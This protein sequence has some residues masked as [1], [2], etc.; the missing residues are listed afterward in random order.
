M[1]ANDN[2]GKQISRT[3][4]NISGRLQ[5]YASSALTI[6]EPTAGFINKMLRIPT[7]VGKQKETYYNE[8]SQEHNVEPWNYSQ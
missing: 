5:N 3:R 7:T 2:R 8:E 6:L 4:S 1:E